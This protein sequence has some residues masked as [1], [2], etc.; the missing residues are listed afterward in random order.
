[1]SRTLARISSRSRPCSPSPASALAA[2]RVVRRR[3]SGGRVDVVAAENFYGNIVAQIGGPH[4]AVT[5]ILR[6]P[7]ADP[8]LFTAG[9]ANGLAVAQAALVIQNG[10]GLRQLHAEA[11]GRR[12]QRATGS[13]SPMA[14]VLGVHGADANPHLWYD[15]PRLDRVAGG[16]RVRARTG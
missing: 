14:D 1:M 10:V 15:V 9:T 12:A 4:V 5:S 6:D 7:N 3:L 2:T 16:D 11:R 8:H 13:S